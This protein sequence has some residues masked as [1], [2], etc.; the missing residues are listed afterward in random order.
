MKFDIDTAVIDMV[1]MGVSRVEDIMEYGFTE[2][3]AE[4]IKAEIMRR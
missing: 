4:E 2:E 1:S 3:Q